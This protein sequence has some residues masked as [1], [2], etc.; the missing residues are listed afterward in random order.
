MKNVTMYCFLSKTIQL[1]NLREK[2]GIALMW[3]CFGAETEG[4]ARI[5]C[6]FF[7]VLL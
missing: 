7:M 3:Q 1:I 5:K 2:N 4:T 6:L